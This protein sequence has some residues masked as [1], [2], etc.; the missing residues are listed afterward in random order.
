[1]ER[2]MRVFGSFMLALSSGVLAESL[3]DSACVVCLSRRHSSCIYV[4]VLLANH[5]YTPSEAA[6]L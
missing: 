2:T 1:M 3:A 4:L 5:R 6:H